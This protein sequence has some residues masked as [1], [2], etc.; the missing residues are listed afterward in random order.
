M[1]LGWLC[2][3]KVDLAPRDVMEVLVCLEVQVTL[4]NPDSLGSQAFLELKGSLVFLVLACQDLLVL[5]DSLVL[6][7]PLVGLVFLDGQ[8]W[9]DFPV[10]LDFQDP[11]ESLVLV[12]QALQ[13]LQE[14]Q[15]LKV[16]LGLKVILVFLETLV[17]QG[18]RVLTVLLDLKVTLVFLVVLA[19]VAFQGHLPLVF[20][21]PLVFLDLLVLWGLLE[22]L[23]LM[24][25][26][27]TVAFQVRVFQGCKVTEEALDFLGHLVKLAHLGFQE[28]LVKK[29]YLDCLGLKGTWV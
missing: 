28:H 29:A 1:N 16:P 8:V 6:L 5:K 27:V 9:M 26:R 24:E 18:G 7:V 20:K 15:V 2:Q 4:A 11:K 13:V 10:S 12:Y 21:V 22:F 19:L 17:H 3:R 14:Y 23:V 25:K